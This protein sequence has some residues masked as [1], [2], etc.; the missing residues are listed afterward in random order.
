MG[1]AGRTALPTTA[2]IWNA[3]S[4]GANTTSTNSLNIANAAFV[5]CFGHVSGSTVITVMASADNVNFYATQSTATVTGAG[6]F[7][8]NVSLGCGYVALQSTNSVTATAVAS[9]K[10]S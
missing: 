1:V 8:I 4:T 3:V 5:S 2:T 10:D 7:C 6:D 9:A